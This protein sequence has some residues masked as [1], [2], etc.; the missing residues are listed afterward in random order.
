MKILI[1]SQYF[2]PESFKIN[3]IA[4]YLHQSGHS[5]DVL[6]GIPNYPE[7]KYYKGYGVFKRRNE[8]YKGIKI[9]R[10]LLLPRGKGKGD[11]RLVPN[12]ISY[13][14]SSCV[15]AFGISK[16]HYD[17]VL[18]FGVSPITQAY[19][20]MLMKKLCNTPICM[21]IYDLWPDTL[22]SHGLSCNML[23]KIVERKCVKIYK[24]FDRLFITS[25][26][27]RK[28]LLEYGCDDEKIRYIPQ[29]VES[30]YKPV[31]ATGN[32]RRRFGFLDNDF[33][34]MF[35]GNLGFAQS[36]ET[37]VECAFYLKHL[38]HIKFVFVGD[39]SVK[40]WCVNECRRREIDNCFF[41]ERQSADNM[42]GIL[43]EA[44][45]L[46]ITLR[47][48]DNYSLTLPGR[49]Q[50]FLAC[51][52]PVIACANGEVA[53]VVNEAHAGLSCQ[54]DNAKELSEC[55]VRMAGMSD[56]ERNMYGINGFQ[57]ALKNFNEADLLKMLE[58]ELT[59]VLN[60][61]SVSDKYGGSV[62]NNISGE[63]NE[64]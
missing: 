29:W 35:A 8:E 9:K 41:M 1:I 2:W 37:I 28:R 4:E 11:L 25:K 27:F 17:T 33:V 43:A 42:P 36:V 10:V 58:T 6:T 23:K 44:D 26:G 19:P 15:A 21:Y 57:Y 39:G 56:E 32:V 13:M 64:A 24:S 5:V 61:T 59:S 31:N 46:L 51:G 63:H 48:R 3:T 30:R 47:D 40:Q 49:L 53:E 22:Y 16:N 7:G 18:V 52:K 62:P 12:Y 34:V 14:L 54:A 45:A 38:K 55:I 60:M 20:A 50:S